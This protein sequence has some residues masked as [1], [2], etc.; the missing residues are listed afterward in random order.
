[1]QMDGLRGVVVNMVDWDIVV[2]EFELLSRYDVCFRTNT[3]GRGM[4]PFIPPSYG[5]FCH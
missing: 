1:M 5:L 2:S 4:K 3:L